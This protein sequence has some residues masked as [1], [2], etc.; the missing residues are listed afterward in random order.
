MIDITEISKEL[1]I[2]DLPLSVRDVAARCS[3]LDAVTLMH[4]LPGL[5]LFIPVSTGKQIVRK[6]IKNELDFENHSNA[7]SLA[8]RL[9]IDRSKLLSL[10]KKIKKDDLCTQDIQMPNEYMRE[11]EDRCGRDL[12]LRLLTKMP[13]P[14]KVY[15]PTG[16]AFL[17]K[18]KY[19]ERAFNGSNTIALSAQL[20]VSEYW[21]R[22]IIRQMYSEKHE[23]LDLF[24]V[25]DG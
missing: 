5:H 16:G 9:G 25:H 20:H 3:V 12:A 22:G 21:V 24:G 14:C 7:S 18:R 8:T 23:Q 19:I 6:I 11:V 13:A 15:I 10:A 1:S 17:I 4:N 2:D